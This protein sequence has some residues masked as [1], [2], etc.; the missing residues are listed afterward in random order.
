M[1]KCF[2]CNRTKRVFDFYKHPRM[3]DGLLGKCK[4]CCRAQSAKRRAQK[5]LDP[6]WLAA[7]RERCRERNQRLGYWEKYRP[8]TKK[9]RLI[10][11][12]RNREWRKKNPQKYA[13]HGWVSNALRS[14]RLKKLPCEVCGSKVRI[15]GHHDDYSKPLE[16]RW[17]CQVHHK[18]LHRKD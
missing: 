17:L 4:A 8:K 7:E 3:K 16:V 18:E 2:V 11:T 15:Q 14:G 1:K 9:A 10:S 5:L 6:Q 12:E 13:A